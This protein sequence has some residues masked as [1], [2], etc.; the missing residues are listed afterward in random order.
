MAKK[1]P[2]SS[3]FNTLKL[4]SLSSDADSNVSSGEKLISKNNIV[5]LSISDE[6]KQKIESYDNLE[7]ENAKYAQ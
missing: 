5:Q 3:E 4:E 1:K 6:V 7:K 2:V